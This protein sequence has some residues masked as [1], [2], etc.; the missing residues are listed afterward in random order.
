MSKHAKRLMLAVTV[1]LFTGA[2]LALAP[3]P[4]QNQSVWSNLHFRYI[5]PEGNRTDAIAGIPGDPLV[6]YAGATS[7][8][9][10]KTR[11]AAITGSPC[12]TRRRPNRSGP[13]VAPSDP[14][15]VWAGTGEPYIRSNISIGDG[16]YK[17]TDAG[18]TWNHMGLEKT[19]RIA[20]VMI[21]PESQYRFRLR[22]GTAYGPQPDRGIFRTTDG[23]KSYEKALFVDE[24][25]G[26]SDLTM[27]PNNPRILF[28][29]TW[30]SKSTPGDGR[31]EGRGAASSGLTT[32]APAGHGWKATDCRTTR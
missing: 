10:W 20:R 8:G 5:G 14:N 4:A 3:A 30:H 11:T 19:G 17:S 23:G 24:N 12:S 13:G 7:G 25:T 21:D 18:K 1:L 28:A 29:G 32:K 31:A 6:Y 16:I 22:V 15:I 26:C 9:V 27:D 2:C